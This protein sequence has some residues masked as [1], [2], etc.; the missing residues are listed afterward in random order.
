[1]TES[2]QILLFSSLGAFLVSLAIYV[3]SQDRKIVRLETLI[4]EKIKC[5]CGK[6]EK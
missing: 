5:G 2:V 6:D 4:N 3:A 1:M